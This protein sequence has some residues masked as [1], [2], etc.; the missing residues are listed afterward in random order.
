MGTLKKI[1]GTLSGEQQAAGA[2]AAAERVLH[3]KMAIF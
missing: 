2:A 1:G 3:S